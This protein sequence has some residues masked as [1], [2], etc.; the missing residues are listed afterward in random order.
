MGFTIASLMIKMRHSVI[1]M[2][3]QRKAC[4]LEGSKI[5]S[6]VEDVGNVGVRLR[7]VKIEVEPAKGTGVQEG[8]RIVKIFHGFNELRHRHLRQ[9]EDGGMHQAVAYIDLSFIGDCFLYGVLQAVAE[10]VAYKI[11][12]LCEIIVLEPDKHT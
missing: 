9:E 12:V 1:T 11:T 2:G 10:I 4:L 5:H 6:L 7:R 3:M 8:V